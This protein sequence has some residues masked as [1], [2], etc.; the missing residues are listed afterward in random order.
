MGGFWILDW[1][2]P[3]RGILDFGFSILDW[4][5]RGKIRN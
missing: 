3:R 5:R 4:A 2:L 1:A